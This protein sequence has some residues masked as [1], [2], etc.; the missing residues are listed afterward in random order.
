MRQP[1][2]IGTTT[3][4]AGQRATVDLDVPDLYTHTGITL[5]VHVIHGKKEGPVLFLSAALH[6]DEI[7][8]VEIIRRILKDKR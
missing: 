7:N 8:G 2:L 4:R 1:I 5:P 3:I 6:G